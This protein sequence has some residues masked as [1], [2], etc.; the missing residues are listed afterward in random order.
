MLRDF[1]KSIAHSVSETH[2]FYTK[3]TDYDERVLP[4]IVNEVLK[5]VGKLS[6]VD[7]NSRTVQHFT[8]DHSA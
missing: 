7:A 3:G 2:F 4:S 5:S 8:V 6:R 1:Q